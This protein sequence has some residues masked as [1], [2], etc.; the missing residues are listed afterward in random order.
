MIGNT[1]P[2]KIPVLEESFVPFFQN[3]RVQYYFMAQVMATLHPKSDN[4]SLQ[5]PQPY[6]I[7]SN[8]SDGVFVGSKCIFSS[9]RS[10]KREISVLS[11]LE[12][13]NYVTS[14]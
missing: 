3:R 7:T 8:L 10:S 4:V 9:K 6:S 12:L 1:S 11:A 14:V 2:T 5:S 13:K